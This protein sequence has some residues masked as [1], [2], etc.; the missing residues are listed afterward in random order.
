MDGGSETKD[1]PSVLGLAQVAF[2]L[3]QVKGF[4]PWTLLRFV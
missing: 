3:A 4:L 1:L 2:T